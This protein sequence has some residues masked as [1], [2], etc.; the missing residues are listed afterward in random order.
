[1]RWTAKHLLGLEGLSRE[2][3]LTILDTAMIFREILDRPVKKVPTLR[4]ITIVNLF[5]EPSTRTRMSFEL[6]EKRLSADTLN[7]SAS[8][9]SLKKGETLRDTARN[10]EAMKVDMVVMRHPSPGAPHFLTR[11]L[12]ASIV[13]AGDGAHEHPTQALLDLYTMRERVG[14]LASK[15]V[16]IV[17]DI[18]HSRVVRSNV[19][20]LRALGAEVTLAGPSTLMPAEA[21]RLG[22][23]VTHDL[24]EAI[25]DADIVNILRIQRERQEGS[26]LPSLR[27]YTKLFGVDASRLP[28]MKDDVVIMHPGP[29]NRGVEIS[30]GVADGDRSVILQQVT[31][32]V[33][34][35]MAV[36]Y[37]LSRVL[38]SERAGETEML[39]EV[40]L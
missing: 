27:E 9:S 38:S 36:I 39:E 7:F 4:G 28:R 8:T 31:N 5:F 37:L 2:E 12:G 34:V 32:G 11:H 1:M 30:P 35:R 20:G 14:D 18:L 19:W 21:E 16:T 3:I 10:I 22:V 24:D 25:E 40:A 26:F 15:R 13:N 6:A 17:G 23:T 33:A 29:I